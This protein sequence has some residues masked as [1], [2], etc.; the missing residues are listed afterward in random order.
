M[1]IKFLLLIVFASCLACSTSAQKPLKLQVSAS[2]VV[3]A[4][5]L[6][7]YRDFLKVHGSNGGGPPLIY[8]AEWIVPFQPFEIE[9]TT[10]LSEFQESDFGS[11]T[12]HRFAADA[13]PPP[14]KL[15]DPA[16]N[17]QWLEDA[18]KDGVAACFRVFSEIVFD[19]S[20]TRAALSLSVYCGSQGSG[21]GAVY[22]KQ[23]G[24]WKL[25]KPCSNW[26]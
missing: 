1:K 21:D 26:N 20:H 2:P 14:S 4:D 9:R 10:C 3:D 18:A 13:F 19:S 8:I 11:K 15:I 12:T 6:A 22:E 25:T 23:N 5:S 17:K 24:V 16:R 7:I